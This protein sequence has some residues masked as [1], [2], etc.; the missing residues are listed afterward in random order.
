MFSFQNLIPCSLT[1]CSFNPSLVP[2][3]PFLFG[4]GEKRV[5]WISIGRFVLQTP[6]FWELLILQTPR[7]WEL[8][9]GVNNYKGLPL[10]D[11][12]LSCAHS[13]SAHTTMKQKAF[14]VINTY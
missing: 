12:P 2:R 4:D 6:R 7:F 1:F 3:P 9:K 8:L 11:V 5:W 14:I 13:T 10:N